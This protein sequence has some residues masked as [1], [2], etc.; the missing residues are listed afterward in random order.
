MSSSIQSQDIRVVV[1]LG[2]PGK[3]Y[4]ATRHNLGFMIIDALA[5]QESLGW[6]R[7]LRFHGEWCQWIRNDMMIHLLKPH[8]FMNRSAKSVHALLKYH[9]LAPSQVLCIQD[10]ITL[11]VGDTKLSVGGGAGGH[12]GIK[13]LQAVLGNEFARYKVGIGQKQPAQMALS[14]FVLG[15]FPEAHRQIIWDRMQAYRE[16]IALI[17]DEGITPAMNLINQKI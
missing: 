6:K 9:K 10:D 13:D 4:V 15:V 12:N 8:T 14:D 3:Q 16:Q 7:S 5:E 11:E 2:N 17:L 1:G